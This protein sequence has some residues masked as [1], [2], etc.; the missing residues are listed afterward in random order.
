M[1]RRAG[2][3]AAALLACGLC[4]CAPD[5]APVQLRAT[6]H[7]FG[8][9]ATLEVRAASRAEAEAAI[10]AAMQRL[11]ERHR[12]WH[13]W[14]S[15]EL[16]ALNARLAAGDTVAIPPSLAPLFEAAL[17]LVRASDGAF[18]PAAGALV[19]L[20]GFHTADY[21]VRAVPPEPAAIARWRAAH[22]R[23]DA[24]VTES[25]EVRGGG[26]VQLDFNAIAEGVASVEVMHLLA[27]RGVRDALL[28]LGGD[29]S[30]MGSAEGR[31]WR[32]ALRD[33]L[34]DSP[35]ATVA[36]ADGEAL[37]AS[38]GYARYLEHDGRRWPH[39]LDPRTGQPAQGALATVVLAREAPRADA[40][41]T[42]LMV[43]GA[44]GMASLLAGMGVACALLVDARGTIHL[45]A[46]FASRVHGLP[47]A[48]P[49][50]LVE[51]GDED[52]GSA[53]RGG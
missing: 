1:I 26:T 3:L 42:A 40:A 51:T 22:R 8:S 49:R 30:A 23:L 11:A 38:G 20:W 21:P 36:L 4:A 10:A 32:V 44:D 50:R 27:A 29:V 41:A 13:P 33:P 18:D 48:R 14:Q 39:V 19:A 5:R 47:P 46:A 34:A 31:P 45:T 2:P 28:D 43:V 16:T 35:L 15:S 9:L 12:Q 52:C 25:G 24:V 17:P 6:H 53:S 37:Y 7:V